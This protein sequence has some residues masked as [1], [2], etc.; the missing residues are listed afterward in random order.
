MSNVGSTN[1]NNGREI[2]ESSRPSSGINSGS[3]SGTKVINSG[4]ANSNNN[5]FDREYY[6]PPSIAKTNSNHEIYNRETSTN[7]YNFAGEAS[8]SG[9]SQGNSGNSNNQNSVTQ[10]PS[11]QRTTSTTS[12]Y[13]YN[14]SNRRTT[15][16]SYN[17][18]QAV[19]T[20]KSTF[21]QGDL[22]FFKDETS[23]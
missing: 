11:N 15:S 8:F 20:K 6:N 10:R 16:N 18:Y 19:T 1:I 9:N 23:V 7:G 4:N 22:P 5:N 14:N 21:F 2:Y 12:N 13:D 3:S 17:P